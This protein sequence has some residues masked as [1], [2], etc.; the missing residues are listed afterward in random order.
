MPNV[1][2]AL[3]L[4]CECFSQE[5]FWL[6]YFSILAH[7]LEMLLVQFLSC[8]VLKHAFVIPSQS[9]GFGKCLRN[10]LFC[11]EWDVKPQLNQSVTADTKALL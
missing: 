4:L 6:P 8:S 3:H 2:M 5:S 11:V 1:T 9:L 7:I 10:D